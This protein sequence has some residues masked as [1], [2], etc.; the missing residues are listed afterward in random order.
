MGADSGSSSAFT[1][2]PQAAQPAGFVERQ[3][4]APVDWSS[5]NSE[6][7][8]ST[9]Y[10]GVSELRGAAN[11][12]AISSTNEWERKELSDRTLDNL[13]VFHVPDKPLK[14]QDPE[15]C[16]TSSI[17]LNLALKPSGV[18][19]GE[20]GVWTVSFIPAYSRFGPISGKSYPPTVNESMLTPA[21]A[22]TP[23][24]GNMIVGGALDVPINSTQSNAIRD[25]RQTTVNPQRWRIFS[26]SGARVEKII[27][28]SNP[29]KSNWM[30]F[31]KLAQKQ[32]SQNLIACQIDG[33]MY[34]YS[35]KS[36]N[37][38]TEL[39]VWYS[40]DY[41]Q[42]IQMPANCE[43]WRQNAANS[44]AN[45]AV[46]VVEPTLPSSRAVDLL[47]RQP[48]SSND[49][50]SEKP[51]TPSRHAS[52]S[53]SQNTL[54]HSPVA[55]SS[56]A[57]SEFHVFDERSTSSHSATESASSSPRNSSR[58]KERHSEERQEPADLPVANHTPV[59]R[60]DI[61][62]AP[63]HRPVPLK[64]PLPIHSPPASQPQTSI[65]QPEPS[66]LFRSTP[67]LT[68]L[69]TLLQDYWR[70]AALGAGSTTDALGALNS[71]VGQQSTPSLSTNPLT[72]GLWVQPNPQMGIVPQ[73]LNASSLTGGRYAA[74]V[75]LPSFAATA[76]QPPTQT[77]VANSSL[78]YA[79]AAAAS[80]QTVVPTAQQS[81]DLAAQFNAVLAASDFG[82]SAYHQLLTGDVPT[83][84]HATPMEIDVSLPSATATQ[85][86]MTASIRSTN[87]KTVSSTATSDPKFWQSNVNGRTRYQ[88]TECA[89]SFG[90]LSNLKVHLR[91]HSGEKPY[92]CPKCH[93]RFSQLAHLQK[94]D[95]VH[96][97]E[98][99]HA[100]S[101]CDKRFSS[102]SN[103]KTH[104]R[105]HSGQRPF[106]CD[107]CHLSF[108]QLVHLKLHQRLHSQTRP[109]NCQSCGRDYI[110]SS[111]LR[112][113][114]KNTSCK[115]Q[116]SNELRDLEAYAN[117]SLTDVLIPD[118]QVTS[119][120]P[121]FHSQ[122]C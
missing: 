60:P 13:C 65:C 89:K 68:H 17:P 84:A 96:T 55:C 24:N 107:I 79:M 59:Q 23:T 56:S 118:S 4:R 71:V 48:N 97:G 1:K 38:N 74:E 119:S 95:L 61:I 93:K 54:V 111:G 67:S 101:Y 14:L 75:S 99:P 122:T 106:S 39:L 109:F 87:D 66:S 30:C 8:T 108:T 91:V 11:S 3:R 98:K 58:G 16:A 46:T 34:F 105:L 37:P 28:T 82:L 31:V 113:H 26:K 121:L 57:A 88:C 100:C 15:N 2:E 41:A 76:F 83:P 112:T 33:E 44:F 80:Q 115:P 12:N 73:N 18:Y 72:G 19:H 90:Q 45:L 94:H 51:Q 7:T 36:I 62:Q 21:E 35:I 32:E 85:P 50:K 6:G 69:S 43:F 5:D 42:R 29:K 47:M 77:P 104:M 25:R 64:H 114:W 120:T 63:L 92:A 78:L 86:P 81:I 103:L 40:R 49:L 110:S 10:N 20:T 116:S 27:D 9:S 117:R 52:S 53:L 22:L 70:R 102:T